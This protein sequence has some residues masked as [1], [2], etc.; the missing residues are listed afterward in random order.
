[1]ISKSNQAAL[2]QEQEIDDAL[3]DDEH[4]ITAQNDTHSAPPIAANDNGLHDLDELNQPSSEEKFFS[5]EKGM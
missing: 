5:V 2:N 1:M 4:L 3:S